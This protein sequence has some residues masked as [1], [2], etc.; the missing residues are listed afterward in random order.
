MSLYSIEFDPLALDEALKLP[1]RHR[2]V[3]RESLEFLSAAPYRSHP[4]VAVKEIRAL[5]GV[6]R[7]HLGSRAR[8]F[9]ITE[10][11][12][13]VVVMIDQSAGVNARTVRELRRRLS[14]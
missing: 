3:L 1:L 14:S 6:W 9:Y 5:R 13:L 8:M 11:S 10:E 2:R 4:G 7:F 12:R